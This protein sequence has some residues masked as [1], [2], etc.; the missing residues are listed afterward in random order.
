[1][2][3]LP[4]KALAILMFA[5]TAIST[6]SGQNINWN[7]PAGGLWNTPANWTPATVPSLT[8]ETAVFSIGGVYT[9]TLDVST[10]TLGS[11]NIFD[12]GCTFNTNSGIFLGLEGGLLNNGLVVLNNSNGGFSS[13]LTF[14]NSAAITGTGTITLNGTSSRSQLTSA[15]GATVT[16]GV[17]HTINGIGRVIGD[18]IND[19]TLSASTSGQSL[20][21]FTGTWINNNRIE[22]ANSSTMNMTSLVIGQGASGEIAVDDGQ[23]NIGSTS[24]AD[25]TLRTMPGFNWTATAGT[26]TFN[27]VH[28]IGEGRTN[29]GVQL[30]LQNSIENDGTLVINAT[31]GGFQSAVEFQNPFALNG[32]GDILLNG[33]SSRSLLRSLDPAQLVTQASTHMIHG[34]GTIQSPIINNGLIVAD[35]ASTTLLLNTNNQ[36]NNN[37]YRIINDAIMNLQ[38]IT[39]DQTGGGT[40]A[41]DDGQ[42]QL[43]STTILDGTI[44]A[45]T[46]T[47]TLISGIN[48]FDQV[49]TSAPISMNSGTALRISNGLVNDSTLTINNTNG[50]FQSSLVFTDSSTLSGSGNT[51]LNGTNSRSQIATDP[52]QTMTIANGHLVNGLGQL[53]AAIINN[54]T[55]ESSFPGQILYFLTNDKVNNGLISAQPDAN[56]T[57]NGI[58]ITQDPSAQIDL[59]DGSMTL[60]GATIIDG[61]INAASGGVLQNS[62]VTTLDQ[63]TSNAP[64][65]MASGSAI[66]ITNGL[67]NND[68]ITVNPTGGGFPSSLIFT[69]STTLSG[70]G[71]V[72]LNGA[73]TRAQLNSSPGETG[74]IGALHTVRGFG[75]I[76]ASLINDGLIN[77]NVAGQILNLLIEDKTNNTLIQIDPGAQIN[78]N[79]IEIDQTAG[80]QILNN[81]GLLTL[82][83][84][85][86]KG[87]TLDA[88]AA[89]SI[90]ISG[91]STYQD[92]DHL[93]PTNINSGISLEIIGTVTNHNT[94]N[95]NPTGGGFAASIISTSPAIINGMGKIVLTGATTRSQINGA[96]LTL[97]VDQTLSGLG[98]VNAPL[99][100]HGTIAPGFSVGE[101]DANAS[102]TLSDSSTYQVEIS[103]EI[104]HD[105][106]DSTSTYHAD[107]VL[108][109]TLIDGF[110]PNTSFV[111]TIVT[112]DAG[113]TGT[114]DTLI[115]PP[116]PADP[117]LSYKIGYFDNEIRIGAVCDS[118]IDFNGEID[119]FD[120]SSFLSL[121]TMQDPAADFNQ[122]GE[123]DFFDI[124]LFLSSFANG[125]P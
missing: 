4:T 58:T 50:G 67:V 100:H 29:S 43:N 62:G 109:V 106:I 104:A 39:V 59:G 52:G 37:F 113:V 116:P 41:I 80:G 56:I 63:V 78:I 14:N 125:C 99:T 55:I 117:R 105:T 84:A 27:T 119:F 11:I 96:G 47:A 10:P 115:A 77:A 24:I 83:G 123:Y 122:D 88:L 44:T 22:V 15:I 120:I 102:I 98:Q 7:N 66:N 89:G 38:T 112:A 23:L 33:T 61:T 64:I 72:A 73:T 3:T 30:F 94:I 93:S 114:Y 87:G 57:V 53:N 6:A 20:D 13:N 91:S 34:R 32:S 21:V 31:N 76:N 110:V 71:V 16:Q 60:N 9:T 49:H 108:N 46:G 36:I 118:D 111:A 92:L 28:H 82:G 40:I 35:F 74:T 17:D 42:L 2:N 101:I 48:T 54:G 5:G 90:T 1:M 97:G 12:T 70:T 51:L 45:G 69:D 103:S 85:T 86:I 19:G 75:Q 124:S 25:G 65:S 107:G 8:T 95:I 68:T 18:Y 121:F 81:D 26:N 79:G